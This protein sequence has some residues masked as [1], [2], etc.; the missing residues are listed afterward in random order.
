MRVSGHFA[1][2]PLRPGEGGGSSSSAASA[3]TR[4]RGG[5]ARALVAA[6]LVLFAA[7]PGVAKE[8]TIGVRAHLGAEDAL[9]RWQATADAISARLGD[10]TVRLIPYADPEA[11][12]EG[13]RRG[14]FDFAI[15]DP[16]SFVRMEVDVGATAMLSLVN[17][18]EDEALIR[19]GSVIFTRRTK[20]DFVAFE[21]LRGKSLMA[22]A[23]NA[24]GGW[25]MVQEEFL[26]RNIVPEDFLG[27]LTF[28]GGN[29]VAVVEA[30]RDGRVDAGV[31]RTGVLEKLAARGEIDL[32]DFRI[33]EARRFPGFPLE[34]STDLYPEW[35]FAKIPGLPEQLGDVPVLP[36]R[37]IDD[38]RQALLDITPGSPAAQQGGYVGWQE[39]LSYLPVHSLLQYLEAPPYE[40][41]SARMVRAALW[42]SRY[43]IIATGIILGGLVLALVSAARRG[44]ELS[45]I[46][47]QIIQRQQGELNFRQ[48]ALDEHAIVSI[49]DARGTIIYANDKFVEIS[50]YSREELLGQDHRI[51]NS[52]VHDAAFFRNMWQTIY[53]GETWSGEI[54]NRRKDGSLYWVKS[55]I[56]PQMGEN[57]RPVKFISIRTDITASKEQQARSQLTEFF[58]LVNDEVYLFSAGTE[59]CFYANRKALKAV[60]GEGDGLGESC[61]PDLGRALGVCETTWRENLRALAEGRL[62]RLSYE[63]GRTLPDG[64]NVPSLVQVQFLRSEWLEPSFFITVTDISERREA[65]SEVAELKVPLDQIDDEVYMFWPDTKKFFYANRAALDRLGLSEREIFDMTPVDLEGGLTFE[66]CEQVLRPMVK[67]RGGSVSFVRRSEG[68]DGRMTAT[69]YD[70][71]FVWPEGH[72]PRFIATLRDV[73]DRVR[74]QEEIRQL[75]SSLD[76]IKN[77]VYVFWPETYK[78]IYLNGQALARTGWG[79]EGWRGKHTFDYITEEEQAKL[80]RNCAKL[81][82]GPRKSMLF[83]T[84]D[85]KG[86]P[87]EI[88]LHLIEPEGEKPR[89]LSVYRDI[90]DRK[91]A[92]K[93][94]AEFIATVSHE[95]R[96]PLTSIKGALGLMRAGVLT[97]DPHKSQKM[98]DIAYSNTKRLTALVNDILDWEKIEAGK[99]TYRMEETDLSRLLR[100]AV[101]ANRGYG[102]EHGVSFELAEPLA[103][104]PCKVDRGRMMQVMANLLSNAAKF[105]HEGGK[106]DISARVEGRNIRVEVRDYGAGIPAEAQARIFERFTQAGSSDVRQRGGTGLGLSITRAIVEAHG[107][108]MDFVSREGEGTTFFFTLPGLHAEAGPQPGQAAPGQVPGGRILVVEDDPDIARLL[109]MILENE[110]YGVRVARTAGEAKEM[111]AAGRFD[112]MTLDLG[113]PDQS[114]ISLLQELR[115]REET[116]NL[117]VVVVSANAEQG[118]NS[119]NGDAIGVIDWLQ[120]PIE[121]EQLVSRLKEAVGQKADDGRR[122][123][124]LVGHDEKF[125]RFVD[126]AIDDTCAVTHVESLAAARENLARRPFDL[127]ILD[128]TLPDGSGVELLPMLNRPPQEATPVVVISGKE[129]SGDIPDRLRNAMARS[130][131]GNDR[132]IRTIGSVIRAHGEQDENTVNKAAND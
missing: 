65:E 94:K 72:K 57:G 74:A 30:V 125:C 76:L 69:E 28:S 31:V 40:N 6:L 85:S 102:E 14:E 105:S 8:I 45:K 20:H 38:V 35:V 70:I 27:E 7:V 36:K 54:R 43:W 131:K 97:G 56:V 18:W 2:P 84:V 21:E 61:F 67:E 33:I 104:M 73:T 34:V 23:P 78:F 82:R 80:E 95:L 29:Q 93:A 126:D 107:G 68:E 24:F 16:S 5:L 92:E 120:K 42:E 55:T 121:E 59:K 10:H 32:D 62:E 114:G 109:S 81:M 12:V 46:R 96:T 48:R 1:K 11:I 75:T 113:L 79:A 39:P 123:I 41:Y 98:L 118:R 90:S 87:L 58:E 108:R 130:K 50:G 129:I 4:G 124:L 77:E 44:A 88:Y 100:D 112:C 52:G 9:A 119:L 51:L 17:K 22:V 15:T 106:V 3:I 71:K 66:E 49:T 132:L 83:E 99:M 37:I 111:L 60:C 26:K 128:L 19:F 103:P 91:K 86:V 64:T 127:V 122:E 115:C 63:I 25:Q 13:A 47:G 117:P 89:F 110:G 101:E 53:R 116:A